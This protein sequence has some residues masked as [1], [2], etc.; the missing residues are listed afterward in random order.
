MRDLA[1]AV[2]VVTGAAIKVLHD[3][4]FVAIEAPLQEDHCLVQFQ[5][6]TIFVG[7][8]VCSY[9]PFTLNFV[10]VALLTTLLLL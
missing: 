7:V 4:G 6:L 3:G 5:N 9:R 8:C 2:R 1:M 10:F